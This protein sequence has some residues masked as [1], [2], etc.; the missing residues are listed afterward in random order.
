MK[1]W[2]GSALRIDVSDG[3]A[4][5]IAL[6]RPVLEGLVGGA[7]LGTWL[8][9][10][11]TTA[12]FDPLAPSAPVVLSFGPLVGTS[13][14][15]S[16][17][18]AVVAKSPLTLR[19]NDALTS[20][21]FAVAGK[22]TGHDAIVIS[23]R[24]AQPSILLVRDAEA[25]VVSCPELWGTDRGASAIEEQLESRYP[26]LAFAVIG[27]AGEHG[28]R[29]AGLSSGHRHAG[30]GGLGA[31][32]GAKRIKAIGI[33][34]SRAVAVASPNR[35]VRLARS[36]AQRALGPATEKYREL[37][38]VA[39]LAA[40]NRVSALPT[41]NFQGTPL[42]SANDLSGEALRETRDAGRAS[43]RSCAIG[44][45]HFFRA[46][47]GGKTKLEY[48]SLFALGPMV[49]V[50]DPELVLDAAKRCDELG[51]DTISAGGTIAFAME[52]H[53]RGLLHGALAERA[54]RFGRGSDVLRMLDEIARR[55]TPLGDLLA[56][57]SR[58]AAA[59]LG[60]EAVGLAPH[61]KGLELP[62]YEPRAVQTLAL[63]LAVSAR[64]ADHN[65]SGAYESDLSGRTDR[66]AGRPDAAGAAIDSENRAAVMDSIIL[67]K[68]VRG[69]FEDYYGEIGELLHAVTG[70]EYSAR[71]VEACGERIVLVKKRFNVREGWRRA[72]D[73]LPLRLLSET[74]LAGDA[75][76]PVGLTKAQL[77]AMIAAYYRGRGWT[78]E[79]AIPPELERR[80]TEDLELAQSG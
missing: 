27:T 71:D 38:T 45:T 10:E 80:L 43:C 65:K 60:G 14:T 37:G 39:N 76:Q 20:S 28:V 2:F 23:G 61:V 29:F 13:L 1:G 15:T 48:E 49:G 41:H 51:L 22:R 3:T 33:L 55:R 75:G 11:S 63:G 67:C 17:K 31:V 47:D 12:G 40:F 44:C 46:R 50:E 36:L 18:L 77:D 54:P 64:G 32:L 24:A 58:L 53:Q 69:V 78:D 59:N 26:G 7:G 35:V 9:G 5:T 4:T 62:G 72:E 25:T 52:C 73:T 19:I 66:L 21:D 56:E 79:G 34:G 42:S 30:R 16:A 74:V 68:F 8:L 57:G 70:T 6:P